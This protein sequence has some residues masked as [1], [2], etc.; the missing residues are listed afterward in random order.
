MKFK[1]RLVKAALNETPRS[2]SETIHY[3]TDL[4]IPAVE[5]HLG[6]NSCLQIL[7]L[8]FLYY[9]VIVLSF[10]RKGMSY[11]ECLWQV[12]KHHGELGSI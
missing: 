9:I 5:I 12:C 10:V 3:T 11:L 7:L 1:N 8:I 2:V 4:F 6:Q